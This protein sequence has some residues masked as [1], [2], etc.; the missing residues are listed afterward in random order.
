MPSSV[1]LDHDGGHDD[2]L[3][4]ALLLAHP[5]KVRLIGCICTDADCFVDDAFSVT[6][7]VMS[8][9]HTR[10][11]VPLFP[12]GVSSFRGVNPFPSLWRSHAKNMDDLPCL[13][14][15]EHVALWDKVKA[16][17]R[18]LVGE[19]LLA[20]L[21]M[22]SPE[23]VTICVTGPLS[24]VA[25]CIEKYGSKFTD[26][27]KECVIM[28]GAV[29][30]GGNVFEST[31][32]GTAEWNIYWDPPAAKVVLACP[33]MRSVL[34][35][36]DS[37]NHVPVTSSLVQRFGSQNECLLSQFA[38]SAWAMCT[39]YELIRPGDGYYAWDVLTAAY[40]LDHNLAEVEPI[41]LEVETNKTKS[42]GR[43]FRSTQ[44]GPCTYVAKHVKADMFYDMVLSSMRCC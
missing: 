38:G 8:L 16:E 17:N 25:W 37:T 2:L 13:N 4:L 12:I 31:S 34:F 30:V 29:D 44:G 33:H 15:P 40:V 3:A 28:G 22:N 1:I 9:V 5:E 36:L 14:L 41:A 23:K 42:E 43:T 32:D 20:D 18:K 26:K 24:N 39:H 11:K 27:V 10:A 19:Q 21:V 7:K 35:S 6:G